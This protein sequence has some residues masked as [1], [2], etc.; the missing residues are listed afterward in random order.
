MGANLCVCPHEMMVMGDDGKGQ[1]HRF[2]RTAC[3]QPACPEE[4]GGMRSI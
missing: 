3:L 4:G 2:A 1:T